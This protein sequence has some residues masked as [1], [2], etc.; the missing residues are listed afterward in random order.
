MPSAIAQH[1]HPCMVLLHQLQATANACKRR[2]SPAA[3]PLRSGSCFTVMPLH[4]RLTPPGSHTC[5][6]NRSI[7]AQAD[8]SRASC[9]LPDASPGA[10]VGVDPSAGRSSTSRM[11]CRAVTRLPTSRLPTGS[12]QHT[13]PKV[14]SCK[15]CRSVL[16]FHHAVQCTLRR[17]WRCRRG[18]QAATEPGHRPRSA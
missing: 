8:Q 9:F 15:I 6:Q 17:T 1:H 7:D 18:Q 2:S 4:V 10:E 14:R 11:A 3:V 13:C 12:L 5:T 16:L